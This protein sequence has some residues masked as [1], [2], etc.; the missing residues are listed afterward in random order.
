MRP[1]T[2][3]ALG[4]LPPRFRLQCVLFFKVQRGPHLCQIFAELSQNLGKRCPSL[5]SEE[6]LETRIVLRRLSEP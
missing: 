3:A 4:H 6:S 5:D 2:V 1:G